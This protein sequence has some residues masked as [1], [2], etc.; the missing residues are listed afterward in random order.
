MVLLIIDKFS[1]LWSWLFTTKPM[2]TTHIPIT[3]TLTQY[4]PL[5]PPSIPQNNNIQIKCPNIITSSMSYH[6]T[7]L[8]QHT[9]ILLL[10]IETIFSTPW[11]HQSTH[12]EVIQGIHYTS[13]THKSPTMN[14]HPPQTTLHNYHNMNTHTYASLLMLP[15]TLHSRYTLHWVFPI[16]HVFQPKNPKTQYCP[17]PHKEHLQ[18]PPQRQWRCIVKPKPHKLNIETYANGI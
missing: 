7:Q 4:N 18:P 13:S 1:N 9:I 16:H 14:T 6:N 8:A 17:L 15:N 11:T 3:N 10:L 12:Q 5:V 2:P